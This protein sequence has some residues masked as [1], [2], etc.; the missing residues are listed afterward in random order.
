MTFWYE[1]VE[2]AIT[3]HRRYTRILARSDQRGLTL[4]DLQIAFFMLF[5]GLSMAS[6][7]LGI[8]LFIHKRKPMTFVFTN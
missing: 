7:L 2:Y 3:T 4:V 5:I 1:Y 8:E 6:L